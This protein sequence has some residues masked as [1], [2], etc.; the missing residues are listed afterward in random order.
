MS[1][2]GAWFCTLMNCGVPLPE[3]RGGALYFGNIAPPFWDNEKA[4]GWAV[5]FDGCAMA[6]NLKMHEAV[7]LIFDFLR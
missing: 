5:V 6:A 4:D 3:F 7:A 1:N 2:G